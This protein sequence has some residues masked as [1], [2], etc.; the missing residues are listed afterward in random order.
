MNPSMEASGTSMGARG[1]EHGSISMV[2]EAAVQTS[3]ISSETG[4]TQPCAGAS[5]EVASTEAS[6]EVVAMVAPPRKLP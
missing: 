4:P 6:V 2:R 1:S 5:M 3:T